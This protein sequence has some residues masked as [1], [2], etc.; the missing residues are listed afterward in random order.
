[1]KLFRTSSIDVVQECHSYFGIELP[2]YLIKKN[3]K[4]FCHG[5]TVWTICFVDIV[6]SYDLFVLL[7]SE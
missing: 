3:E 6:V 2:S 4:S 7:C 1:M 5:L